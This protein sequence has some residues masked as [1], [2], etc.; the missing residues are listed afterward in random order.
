MTLFIYIEQEECMAT[1]LVALAICLVVVVGVMK[2]DQL[3]RQSTQVG[4]KHVVLS[5]LPMKHQLMLCNEG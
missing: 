1:L 2:D 3:A 4:E 5:E